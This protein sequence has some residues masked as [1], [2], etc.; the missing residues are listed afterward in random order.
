MM[1]PHELLGVSAH[2]SEEELRAAYLKKVKEFPPDQAPEQFEIMRDAYDALRDPRQ[3]T[4][5]VLT[6][7]DFMKPLVRLLDG[8]KARRIYAGPQAWREVLQAK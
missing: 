3:R 1:N 7:A 8:R 2:A 4:Q 5:A 6:N